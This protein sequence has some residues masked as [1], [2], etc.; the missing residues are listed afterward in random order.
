M[1][2]LETQLHRIIDDLKL[3]SITHFF[4]PVVVLADGPEAVDMMYKSLVR[5]VWKRIVILEY[6][7]YNITA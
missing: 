6:A 3:G 2:G 7:G 4:S 5:G 1:S